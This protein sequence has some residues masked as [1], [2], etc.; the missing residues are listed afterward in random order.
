MQLEAVEAEPLGALRGRD[1]SL[2]HAGKTCRIERQRQSFALLMRHRRG[3][4]RLPAAFGDRD[5]LAA[6]PWRMAGR[7]A[8]GMGE[9]HD[10]RSLG[11]LAH[12]RHDRLQR[13]FS[14]VVPQPETARRDA[15]DRLHGRGLDAEH[16][17]PRQRQR[18]DMGEMPVIGLA[19]D[20]GVLA[21]RRHHD[22]IGQ[23]KA[24]QFYRR[25]QG[26]HFGGFPDR[27]GDRCLPI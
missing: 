23:R 2:S 14:R 13:G 6:V 3:S 16:R 24:T 21:H 8:A 10:D 27:R 17:G 4:L 25:K 26:T 5:Q 15:A 12:R 19:V 11:M 7:L 20:G 1:E 18:V 22:A 9:L